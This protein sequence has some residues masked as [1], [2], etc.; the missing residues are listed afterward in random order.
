MAMALSLLPAPLVAAAGL[1]P[2]CE[3]GPDLPIETAV[4]LLLQDKSSRNEL[5]L[6]ADLAQASLWQ[7]ATLLAGRV[8]AS[9]Q[10]MLSRWN[11]E[12]GNRPAPRAWLVLWLWFLR[13]RL[14]RVSGFAGRQRKMTT[15]PVPQMHPQGPQAPVRQDDGSDLRD[16]LLFLRALRDGNR[17]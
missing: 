2:L 15:A 17:G 7:R 3:N 11:M 12:Q 4:A 14:R 16:H 8:F 6:A 13:T 10:T 9:R 5:R 1:R